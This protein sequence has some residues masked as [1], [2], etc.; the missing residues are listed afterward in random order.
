MRIFWI[1]VYQTDPCLFSVPSTFLTGS[2]LTRICSVHWCLLVKLWLMMIPS[3]PLSSRALAQICL[4]DA[5]PTRD[6]WSMIEGDHLFHIVSPSTGSESNVSSN[7][8]LFS[9]L[10]LKCPY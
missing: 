7:E 8:Y 9:R 2:G 1:V 4:P 6:T 3:A 10:V 5:L